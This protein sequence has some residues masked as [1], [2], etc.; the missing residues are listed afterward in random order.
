MRGLVLNAQHKGLLRI[1]FFSEPLHR[2]VGDEVGAVALFSDL[3]FR[4]QKIGIVIEPL[5]RQDDPVV[6]PLRFTFHVILAVEHRLVA[7][8][9]EQLRESLLIPVELVA[10][11]PESVEVAVLARFDDRP[12]RT[13][14]RVRAVAALEDHALR[15]KL[16]DIRRGIDRL[17]PAVV[18]PDRIRRMVVGKDEYNVR[19]FVRRRIRR[20]GGDKGDCEEREGGDS[21]KEEL[22]E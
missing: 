10:I 14:D 8:G 9:L 21:H 22:Y 13:A 16:I 15:R 20:Q 6:I 4:R 3:P 12:H 18:G 1:A 11:L 17:Q 7:R 19:P 5:A 2:H